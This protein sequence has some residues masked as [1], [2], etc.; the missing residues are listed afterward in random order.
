MLEHLSDHPSARPPERFAGPDNPMR[1]LTRA[2]ADGGAWTAANA[3]SVAELFDGMAEDWSATHVD[4]VK[5]APVDD[6]LDRGD[7][8]LAGSWLELGAGTGAG[9]RVLSGR[10]GSLITTDLSFEMLSHAPGDLAPRVQADAA[11]LPFPAESFDAILLINMLLF[12]GEVDRVLRGHGVVL[13]VNT[14]GDQTP[15]HLPADD[16]LVALPGS[17]HGRTA[18][19]GTGFWLTARRH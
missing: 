6:A 10:V 5:R 8:P 18:Q 13:W 15:I 1:Q 2:V 11:A 16:V 7:V 12:P 14:M 3:D 17:W 19:A 9:A 4:P